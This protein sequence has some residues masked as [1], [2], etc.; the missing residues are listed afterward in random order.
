MADLVK[1]TMR[2]AVAVIALNR[3][4][5]NALTPDLRRAL[6]VHMERAISDR[7]A[8][9]IVLCGAGE[10][11]CP[12]VDLS[13]YNSDLS[14]PWVAEL[15]QQIEQSPKPVVAALHGATMGG[16][17]ELALAAHARV[18]HKATRLAMPDVKLGLIPGAGATQRLPRLV[19]AQRAL[20]ILLGGQ[21]IRAADPRL[22][23]LIT[24]LT[25]GAPE[26]AAC[27]LA[28]SLARTGQWARTCDETVG[29]S[30][31]EGYQASLRSIANQMSDDGG[32]SADILRCVEAAQLLPFAQ[33][34]TL[35]QTL[36]RERLASPEAR[37]ARHFVMAERFA[38]IPPRVAEADRVSIRQIALAG[39]RDRTGTL[40][41]ML[42][43]AGYGVALICTDQAEAEAYGAWIARHLQQDVKAGRLND[44]QMQE[45]LSLVEYSAGP[46]GLAKADLVIDDGA[47]ALAPP[48]D[49]QS[50]T[51]WALLDP[52]E[53]TISRAN[54]LGLKRPVIGLHAYRPMNERHIVE[55]SGDSAASATGLAAVMSVVR[56]CGKSAILTSKTAGVVRQRLASALYLAAIELIQNGASPYN[57][58][59]GARLIGFAQGPFALMDRS[60]LPHV[61]L[62]V[63][64]YARH[65][66]LPET[67]GPIFERF[68]KAGRY[69][70][71]AG[72]GFYSYDGREAARD[73]T[74]QQVLP[75]PRRGQAAKALSVEMLGA[76]LSGALV[77]EATRLM[78]ENAVR[79]ASDLDLVMVKGFGFHRALGGPLLQADLR[80]MFYVLKD[81]QSLSAMSTFW[82]PQERIKDMVKAGE[83]FFGRSVG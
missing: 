54:S 10:G 16:G 40:A 45:R 19:G 30:D 11:F 9:A 21:V 5:S 1:T 6:A 50:H 37:G 73:D 60:G 34:L 58:D 4:G 7:A 78:Q 67:A 74:L 42:L 53:H 51:I 23:R 64:R 47:I 22:H 17:L 83:G 79:R 66:G 56:R 43:G 26:T 12:G 8:E 80:G 59:D 70:R 63:M 20:E 81:M 71:S 77:N 48:D 62:Q 35:E 57:V 61:Q 76:A 24:Q 49:L 31:P 33:G 28:Q 13:E 14:E 52:G 68:V 69:G 41:L 65:L 75:P 15:C 18:A 55:L 36:F 29:L 25:E 2:D 72:K 44:A 39:G 27:Q 38:A 32:A 3:P 82:A 46:A